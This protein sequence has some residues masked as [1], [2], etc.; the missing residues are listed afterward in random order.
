M[1]TKK[2]NV[3]TVE[4]VAAAPNDNEMEAVTVEGEFT[5]DKVDNK[6]SKK[7]DFP[8]LSAKEAFVSRK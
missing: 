2:R 3:E 6:L 7:P 4:E 8:A 1:S 5:L